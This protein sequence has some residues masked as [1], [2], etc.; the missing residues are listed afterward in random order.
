MPI[1]LLPLIVVLLMLQP[2]S[3]DLYLSSLPHLQNSF[4]ASLPTVQLTLSIFVLLFGFAQLP[5]GALSDR[6][7]RRPSL[8]FGLLLY[9]ISS[10]FC[11]LASSITLLILGRALQA[12]GCCSAIVNA[13]AIIR[14]SYTPLE[15]PR[16]VARAST[17]LS[18]APILGP[19]IGSYLQVYCGWQGAFYALTIYSAIILFLLYRCLPETNQH[20][21]KQATQLQGITEN[22]RYV[23]GSSIFWQYAITGALSYA[24]IFCFI[25]GSSF[26]LITVLKV[27]TAYFGY[28]FA[29]GVS[30]YWLGALCC[31][32][33]LSRIEANTTL[34]IGTSI[35]IFAALI[36]LSAVSFNLMHSLTVILPMFLIMFAHGIN[37]PVCQA[38]TLA[39]FAKQA[40][41]AAGLLGTLFM[42]AA[43]I[44]GSLLSF[45]KQ[46]TL[47][48]LASACSII[49]LSNFVFTRYYSHKKIID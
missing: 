5:M 40:G 18:L 2:L 14:D 3:T 44:T 10:I 19:I 33:M 49:A 34:K 28:C 36:F 23:L 27:P 38:K 17:W 29:L 12:I 46:N 43:F 48:P 21:N 7:G 47:L 11:M 31:Q 35:G 30:G 6:F 8:L 25:A 1:N 42:L 24:S 39:P 4:S 22:I 37:F 13:R 20:Q 15:A 32:K 16:V 41:T 9:L 26:A 45:F